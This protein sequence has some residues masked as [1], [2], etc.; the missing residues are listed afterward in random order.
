MVAPV[1]AADS[2]FDGAVAAAAAGV[3]VVDDVV[4][5]VAGYAVAVEGTAAAA[6]DVD[7]AVV[8]PVAF[9]APIQPPHKKIRRGQRNRYQMPVN[10]KGTLLNVKIKLLS[11]LIN[12]GSNLE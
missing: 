7:V 4:E 11:N 1:C 9:V 2:G 5:V 10:P 6:A 3:A 8:G 12:S